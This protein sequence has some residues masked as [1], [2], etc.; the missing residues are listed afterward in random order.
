MARSSRA[1]RKTRKSGKG[2]VLSVRS[3]AAVKSFEKLL[4]RGP[5]TLVYVN[6]KW[7]GACH[8]FTDKVW[9][10]VSQLK[11]KSMNLASVDSEMIG[12]TSLA[13]VPRKFF[14]TLL[15]VGKDGKAAT[16]KDENGQPT[17]AMPRKNTL[18]EDKELFSKL[19][20][21][22]EPTSMSNGNRMTRSNKSRAPNTPVAS[23]MKRS[24]SPPRE[25]NTPDEDSNLES[26]PIGKSPFESESQNENP[27]MVNEEMQNNKP[28]NSMTA[29]V[30]DVASDLYAS[31]TKAPSASARVVEMKG[32]MSGG[33]MLR[34]IRNK[35]A[36]LKAMLKLRKRSTRRK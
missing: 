1:T 27:S 16:F 2:K 35:T 11:N 24:N 6:A 18:S 17:N 9:G 32:G 19:V 4:K 10:P 14:P 7:C 30:P 28:R 21:T 15:L 36:S 5:L 26:S 23:V 22:P 29:T 34:A 13:S 33:K 12:K 25:S 8:Q 3:S 31:Q 20:Q